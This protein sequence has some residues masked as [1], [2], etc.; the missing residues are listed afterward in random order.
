MYEKVTNELPACEMTPK[1]YYHAGDCYRKLGEYVKSNQCHQSICDRYP[2]SDFEW[3]AFFQIGRNYESMGKLG[4]ISKS[5]ADS[6]ARDAY[7]NILAKYPG[8]P[9]SEYAKS[10]IAYK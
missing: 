1:A 10:W 8:S 5:Q 4:V 7:N 6:K 9:A 2:M 3:K